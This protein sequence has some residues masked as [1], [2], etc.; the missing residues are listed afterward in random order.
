MDI[1]FIEL[2]NEPLSAEKYIA[3]VTDPS[4]G[5]IS[6]FIGTTR[7]NFQ[8]KAVLHLEYEAFAP[9]ALKE[10]KVHSLS[11]LIS[12]FRAKFAF[13]VLGLLENLHENSSFRN[14][15]PS[16]PNVAVLASVCTNSV[17]ADE[18]KSAQMLCR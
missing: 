2:K 15:V 3:L 18:G 9:M 6:T 13:V 16:Q 12:N 4:A 17:A 10:L 1:S 11:S 8:G 7:N 14:A 5:A